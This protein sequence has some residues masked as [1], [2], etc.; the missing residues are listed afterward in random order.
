MGWLKLFSRISIALVWN[1]SRFVPERSGTLAAGYFLGGKRFPSGNIHPADDSWAMT[2]EHCWADACLW[3]RVYPS[4]ARDTAGLRSWAVNARCPSAQN[5]MKAGTPCSRENLGMG[6]DDL[7]CCTPW[8]ATSWQESN[9]QSP[10]DEW[11]DERVL[12]SNAWCHTW[13]CDGWWGFLDNS[14]TPFWEGWGYSRE[15]RTMIAW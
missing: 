10:S 3:A 2:Q 9:G 4:T 14:T 8:P 15:D 7:S 13:V 5:T 12:T 11:C 6:G 1:I